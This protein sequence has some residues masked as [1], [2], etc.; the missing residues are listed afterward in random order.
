VAVTKPSGGLSPELLAF[1]ALDA[2]LKTFV[3]IEDL[4]DSFCCKPSSTLSLDSDDMLEACDAAV[5]E[6]HLDTDKNKGM[7]QRQ[8]DAGDDD[9]SDSGVDLLQTHEG[10]KFVPWTKNQELFFERYLT[11]VSPTTFV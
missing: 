1:V 8:R 9:D 7:D 6:L 5:G 10:D 11:W 4:D 3:Q 2:D